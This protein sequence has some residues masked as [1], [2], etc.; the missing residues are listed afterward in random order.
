MSRPIRI[1]LL[2]VAALAMLPACVVAP[3]DLPQEK[4]SAALVDSTVWASEEGAVTLWRVE[5]RGDTARDT[6]ADVLTPGPV[7]A[8]PKTGVV[9]FAFDTA[10]GRVRQGFR[11][12]PAK[13]RVHDVVLSRDLAHPAAAPTPSPDGLHV[14]YVLHHG[15]S[16]RAAVRIYPR[17]RILAEGPPV[18]AAGAR[19]GAHRA[20]WA[21]PDTFEI[22]VRISGEPARWMRVRGAPNGGVTSVDTVAAP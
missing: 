17:G 7:A 1:P 13:R 5:V 21:S 8:V 6:I 18:P 12:D 20:R 3:A 14:A 2:S 11:Y 15:D 22:D 19:R 9:G 4:F 10:A 16:A